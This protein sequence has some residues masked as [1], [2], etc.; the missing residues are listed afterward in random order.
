MRGLTRSDLPLDVAAYS[1]TI[2]AALDQPEQVRVAWSTELPLDAL[3]VT[4]YSSGSAPLSLVSFQCMLQDTGYPME[5][6]MP[7]SATLIDGSL[8]INQLAERW[9]GWGVEQVVVQVPALD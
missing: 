2:L 4:P 1:A 3:Q 7:D 5:V 6:F 9:V 8:D